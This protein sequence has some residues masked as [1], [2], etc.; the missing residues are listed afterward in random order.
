MFKPHSVRNLQAAPAGRQ[1]AKCDKLKLRC[2]WS[3]Q[4]ASSVYNVERVGGKGSA[5]LL[6]FASPFPSPFLRLS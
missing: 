3:L 4:L 2:A 6:F 5:A 1:G